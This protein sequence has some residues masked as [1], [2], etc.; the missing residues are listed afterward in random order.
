MITAKQIKDVVERNRKFIKIDTRVDMENM[1][2]MTMELL[3]E[4]GYKDASYFTRA[5]Y[6]EIEN[7]DTDDLV[8]ERIWID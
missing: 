1:I 6:E 4:A 7:M 5:L 3:K 2:W 8:Q